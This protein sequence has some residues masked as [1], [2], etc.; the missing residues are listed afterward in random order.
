M[1]Y[2][3]QNDFI[4]PYKIKEIKFLWD[5]FLKLV[6]KHPPPPPDHPHFTVENTGKELEGI[7]R[8]ATRE[9]SVY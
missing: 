5:V 6:C 1:W 4:T 7:S 9:K 3:N 2:V 8:N